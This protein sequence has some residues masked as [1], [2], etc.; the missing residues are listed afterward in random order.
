MRTILL[1]LAGMVGVP[2]WAAPLEVHYG[3]NEVDINGDGVKDMIVRSR[4]E[5]GNAHSFDR[6]LV[7]VRLSGKDYPQGVYEVPKGTEWDYKFMTSEGADCLRTGYRFELEQN[8]LVV[9]QYSLDG[10]KQSFCEAQRMAVT[11]Y[12]L[13]DNSIM[14]ESVAPF[15]LRKISIK[16]SLRKYDNVINFIH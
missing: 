14:E 1:F 12:K 2:V 7:M 11:T 13:T 5:N 9:T 8:M 4:W 15:Y 10:G 3:V 16:K 6:Y